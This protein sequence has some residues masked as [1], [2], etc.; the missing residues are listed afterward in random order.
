M[1][2]G[3]NI[4]GRKIEAMPGMTA[5][6]PT[7]G[8][9]VIAK[10]GKV[11]VWHWAH[12]ARADCDLW[13][14][15]ETLWH[16][17]WKSLFNDVE[18]TIE[19]RGQRHRADAVTAYGVVI[20]LQ[21][22]A[23]SPEEIQEREKFYGQMVWVFDIQDAYLNDRFL[24]ADQGTHVTFRWKHPRKSLLAAKKSVYLDLDGYW[25]LELHKLYGGSPCGGGGGIPILRKDFNKKYQGQS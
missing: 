22:S 21:H 10:C 25:L 9:T 14:E 4:N 2:Y 24:L 23:I 18:V 7:C 16:R 15:P 6:C 3:L 1:Q 5:L 17:E 20:E 19:K 8:E 11:V 13:F 12:Q